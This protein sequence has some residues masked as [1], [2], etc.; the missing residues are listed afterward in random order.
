MKQHADW[1]GLIGR[2]VVVLVYMIT[3]F[4]FLFFSFLLV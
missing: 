4:F 2:K 1:L 3:L